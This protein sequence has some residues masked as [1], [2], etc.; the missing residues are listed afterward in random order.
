VHSTV[1]EAVGLRPND[2]LV[3]WLASRRVLLVLDNLEHLEGIAAIISDL[4]VGA[5]DNV[6][7]IRKGKAS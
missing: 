5:D 4:L 1:A 3:G 2:D 6:T 7:P